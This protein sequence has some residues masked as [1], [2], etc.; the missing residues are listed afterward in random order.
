[1]PSSQPT[2][3]RLEASLARLEAVAAKLGIED[4]LKKQGE[5]SAADL[6]TLIERLEAVADK[7]DD[8]G[9]GEGKCLANRTTSPKQCPSNHNS[10]RNVLIKT[11]FYCRNRQNCRVL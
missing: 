5:R 3:G 4:S 9:R 6:R 10:K 2:L 1:M 7:L 8:T 11:F